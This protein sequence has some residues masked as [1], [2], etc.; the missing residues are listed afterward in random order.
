[1]LACLTSGDSPIYTSHPTVEAALQ[2]VATVPNFTWVPHLHGALST[3]PSHQR[4]AFVVV[5]NLAVPPVPMVF[6]LSLLDV[7]FY[8]YVDTELRSSGP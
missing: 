1:M 7:F 5:D 8:L 4:C 6:S 3:E 2:T